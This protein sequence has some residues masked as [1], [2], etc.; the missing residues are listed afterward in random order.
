MVPVAAGGAPLAV[1]QS[2]LMCFAGSTLF[3]KTMVPNRGDERYL[4]ASVAYHSA[5]V[6][7]AGLIAWRRAVLFGWFL[8]RAA[9]LPHHWMTRSACVLWWSRGPTPPTTG[10]HPDPPRV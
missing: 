5:V 6:V 2:L 7:A 4:L 9:W 10:R 1:L 8:A 3:V